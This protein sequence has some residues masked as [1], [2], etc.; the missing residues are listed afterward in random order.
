[1]LRNNAIAGGAIKVNITK[2]VGT[3]LRVKS[4]IDRD[5]LNLSEEQAR[6]FERSAVR[7]FNLA[8]DTRE[9]DIE[10]QLPFSLLQALVF[11][12]TLE[13]G[14][15]IT[16]MPRLRRPGSPYSLKLQIIEASRLCNP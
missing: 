11:L 4:Q 16:N 3:G 2:V 14:D 15:V 1:M 9:I 5:L 12:K 6:Q 10:R 13:D 8:T 7:E